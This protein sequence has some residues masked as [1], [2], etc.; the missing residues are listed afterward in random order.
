MHFF[1]VTNI[2]ALGFLFDPDWSKEEKKK[3][4]HCFL[5]KENR[6]AMIYA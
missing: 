3:N 4:N 2:A 6:R 1:K 5:M